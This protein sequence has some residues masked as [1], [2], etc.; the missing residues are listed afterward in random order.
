[1]VSTA[2]VERDHQV[3]RALSWVVVVD[4]ADW[5]DIDHRRWEVVVELLGT[6]LPNTVDWSTVVADS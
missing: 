3:A 1:V 2:S 5:R 4:T 6:I